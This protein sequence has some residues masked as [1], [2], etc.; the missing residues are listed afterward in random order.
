MNSMRLC[1]AWYIFME[2][3]ASCARVA[4]IWSS[5]AAY[6]SSRERETT[7]CVE[8]PKMRERNTVND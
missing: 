6:A 7:K 5:S 3:L 1:M 2:L 4:E 8:D